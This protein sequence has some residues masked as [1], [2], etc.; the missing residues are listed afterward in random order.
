MMKVLLILLFSFSSYAS[1]TEEQFYSI[2][3]DVV[4]SIQEEILASSVSISLNLNW[5]SETKN[6][7]ANRDGNKAVLNIHGGYARIAPMTEGSFA[8]TICHELGHIVGGFPQ[9]MPTKKYSSEGQADYFASNICLKKY[10]VTRLKKVSISKFHE[11]L[12]L[13]NFSTEKEISLCRNLMSISLD[14]L[15]VENFL[16]PRQAYFESN[17]LDESKSKSRYLMI[18]LKFLVATQL[19]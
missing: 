19:L 16:T 4:E 3:N 5:K 2:T 13:E 1:I 11:D 14:K 15:N 6:A 17:Q 12:C 18:I 7:G 9:V 8:S 10:L